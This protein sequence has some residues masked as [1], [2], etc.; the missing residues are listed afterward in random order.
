[1]T[2][3]RDARFDNT[4][5]A[6]GA[7]NLSFRDALVHH[8]VVNKFGLW[9]LPGAGPSTGR[10]TRSQLASF[11]RGHRLRVL[12]YVVDNGARRAHRLPARRHGAGRGDRLGYCSFADAGSQVALD[13]NL[14]ND[15]GGNALKVSSNTK[16]HVPGGMRVCAQRGLHCPHLRHLAT[17]RAVPGAQVQ[18]SRTVNQQ[19]SVLRYRPRS[20]RGP[21]QAADRGMSQWG[22]ILLG[23]ILGPLALA[24]ILLMPSRA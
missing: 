3:N 14:S 6:L 1:M 10:E 4:T 13:D 8:R 5:F 12:G 22:G 20:K 18:L 16:G 15:N 24:I 11:S 23:L 19:V 21:T 9:H 17:L 7:D 2:F